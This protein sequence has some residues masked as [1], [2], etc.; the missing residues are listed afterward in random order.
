MIPLVILLNKL[1]PKTD[2]DNKINNTIN[3]I[4]TLNNYITD[5]FKITNF[6]YNDNLDQ[7]ISCILYTGQNISIFNINDKLDSH[8]VCES[9]D[10]K[11]NDGNNE[12]LL[13][14][15]YYNTNLL[16]QIKKLLCEILD[17]E[18][19]IF[20]FNKKKLINLIS[21]N[22][23]NNELLIFLASILNYN[24]MIYFEDIN[25]F[26]IYYPLEK[27]NI[28][29]KI[30]IIKYLEDFYTNKYSY[31]LLIQNRVFNFRVFYLISLV[32]NKYRSYLI[33]PFVIH[34]A[35]EKKII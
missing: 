34:L 6:L 1:I 24:I 5:N 25:I 7:I 11:I 15:Y 28:K 10:I 9:N 23:Y 35:K 33:L 14:R 2:I 32:N 16:N 21:L 4:D 18:K 8:L 19:Y 12:I 26:K 17:N 27:L 22:D 20:P 29:K 3:S 31:Q 13:N 30:I